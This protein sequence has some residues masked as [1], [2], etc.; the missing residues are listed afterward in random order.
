LD[1]EPDPTEIPDD[2]IQAVRG[3]IVVLRTEW[4][5]MYPENPIASQA[6]ESEETNLR[7]PQTPKISKPKG[8]HK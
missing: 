6:G 1:R 8:K 7:V 2:V 5:R 3:S 4:D